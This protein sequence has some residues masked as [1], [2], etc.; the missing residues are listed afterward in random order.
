MPL[1]RVRDSLKQGLYK[2]PSSAD[3]YIASKQSNGD[4]H[5]MSGVCFVQVLRGIGV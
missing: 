2:H 3:L 4:A 5:V 1:G